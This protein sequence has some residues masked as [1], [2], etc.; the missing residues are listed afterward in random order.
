MSDGSAPLEVTSA[1]LP[2]PVDKAM[3]VDPPPP[4]YREGTQF[5]FIVQMRDGRHLRVDA[6]R[7]TTGNGILSF[8]RGVG[9]ADLLTAAFEYGDWKRVSLVDRD[10]GQPCGWVVLKEKRR[11]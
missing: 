6:D 11:T 10:T 2:A 9:S 3:A 1:D 7:V 4:P 5:S 8:F